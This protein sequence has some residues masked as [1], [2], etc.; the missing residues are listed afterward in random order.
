[1]YSQPQGQQGQPMMPQ[2]GAMATVPQ[3]Q[4]AAPA[5]PQAVIGPPQVM[6]PPPNGRG[7]FLCRQL[8]MW[9]KICIG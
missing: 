6:M 9:F 3:P 8:N 1:M 2:Y 7:E 4:P 5:V